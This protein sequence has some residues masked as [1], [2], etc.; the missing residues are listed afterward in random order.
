M[1]LAAA[2]SGGHA[3]AVPELLRRFDAAAVADQSLA[4]QR[5]QIAAVEAYDRQVKFVATIAGAIDK[6][7]IRLQGVPRRIPLMGD[8]RPSN[9]FDSPSSARWYSCGTSVADRGQ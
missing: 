5:A 9:G 6:E 3:A 7:R 1:P 4:D 8:L 2:I